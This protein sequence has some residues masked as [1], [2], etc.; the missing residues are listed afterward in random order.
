MALVSLA[1]LYPVSPYFKCDTPVCV[2]CLLML[3]AT[4]GR[5][6]DRHVFFWLDGH[7]ERLTAARVMEALQQEQHTAS[8][9]KSAGV[10]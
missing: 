5:E 3:V 8:T 9:S 4:G 1:P 2:S 6:V 10:G 7:A